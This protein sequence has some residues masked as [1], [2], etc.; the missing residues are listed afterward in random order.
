ML[1]WLFAICGGTSL[2][3]L[4]WL[5]AASLSG[6]L[7]LR[8]R[9]AQAIHDIHP[10]CQLRGNRI[11]GFPRHASSAENGFLFC[12]TFYLFLRVFSFR[13]QA[14]VWLG[15]LLPRATPTCVP[16]RAQRERVPSCHYCPT[17]TGGA[18]DGLFI[19]LL[20]DCALL[21]WHESG[22]KAQ[23]DLALWFMAR[24]RMGGQTGIGSIRMVT[25]LPGSVGA[26][27]AGSG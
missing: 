8:L 11:V 9:R 22:Q 14:A 5:V 7:V 18:E 4:D 25:S 13:P 26:D 15:R 3:L 1:R 19:S 6:C 24:L 16:N 17:W 20:H 23:L 10:D 27:G 21:A 2:F 12:F